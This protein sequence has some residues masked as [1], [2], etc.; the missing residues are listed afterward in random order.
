MNTL[1]KILNK[2]PVNKQPALRIKTMPNDANA[3]GDI[4][5]GW[6]MSQMDIAGGIIAA[7][8]TRGAVAT[9]A[10]KELRFLQPLY[11]YDLVSFY[12]DVTK[13]GKTSLTVFIEV[14]AQ[15]LNRSNET[16]ETLKVGDA[17]FVYVAI[18]EPGIK[19]T[20]ID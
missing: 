4:F 6:L 9:V 10:V 20:I 12:A 11:V 16:I 15:R 18:S 1:Q 5:G 17:T 3:A 13:V 19:R 8:E 2:L 7:Q 14:Y